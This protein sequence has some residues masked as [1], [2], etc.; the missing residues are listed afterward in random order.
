MAFTYI[1][2]EEQEEWVFDE[3]PWNFSQNL[4]I[5][6]GKFPDIAFNIIPGK[7]PT[8]EFFPNSMLT[9][10]SQLMQPTNK[11]IQNQ[12]AETNHKIVKI[13]KQ[14]CVYKYT[15]INMGTAH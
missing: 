10:H 3:S 13:P 14:F 5:N 1:D 7:E 2:E 12:K 6:K 8:A 4:S 15:H 9:S 11:K